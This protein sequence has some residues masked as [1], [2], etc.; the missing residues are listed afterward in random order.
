M[1]IPGVTESGETW[2]LIAELGDSTGYFSLRNP[3]IR[4]ERMPIFRRTTVRH[5]S[6]I[7]IEGGHLY[8]KAQIPKQSYGNITEG[9][10]KPPDQK[11]PT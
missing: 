8:G 11:G 6:T 4:G 7:Q 2:V 10:R 9:R 1:S 3:L 5:T